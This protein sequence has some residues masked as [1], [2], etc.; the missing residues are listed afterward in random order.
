MCGVHFFSYRPEKPFLG[1]SGQKIKIVIV[2]L[3]L[4]PRL[5]WICGIQWCSLF[6]FL[7]INIF[8]GQIWSKNSKLF[9]GKF[10]TKRS[11][12]VYFICFR[13]FLSY[14][15]EVIECLLMFLLNGLLDLAWIWC[16]LPI[17][18]NSK[19]YG[20]FAFHLTYQIKFTQPHPGY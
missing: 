8:L 9:K 15:A 20:V 10:D 7:T 4:V 1:K 5:I 19:Q 6:L 17:I 11:G 12:G 2:C 14:F 3:N 18:W 16:A 13:M